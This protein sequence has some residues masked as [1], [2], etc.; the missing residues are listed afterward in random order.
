MSTSPTTRIEANVEYSKWLGIFP[1]WQ[2]GPRSSASDPYFRGRDIHLATNSGSCEIVFHFNRS[3]NSLEW[4]TAD[5]IWSQ[6]GSCPTSAAHDSQITN[7]SVDPATATLTIT[8]NPNTQGS[9][10]YS[11]NFVKRNRKPK[12]WDPIIIHD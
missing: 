9:L 5:P 6:P 4:D 2:I 1:R 11:L 12:R 10:H 3:G 7:P 8:D